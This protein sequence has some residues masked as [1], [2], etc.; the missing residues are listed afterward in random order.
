MKQYDLKEI[1]KAVKLLQVFARDRWG[2]C[3]TWCDV[4]DGEGIC[5]VSGEEAEEI[6]KEIVDLKDSWRHLEPINGWKVFIKQMVISDDVL[7]YL[8]QF[9]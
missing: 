3:D 6:R 8:E 5:N 4:M 9:K 2:E 1:E 7:K